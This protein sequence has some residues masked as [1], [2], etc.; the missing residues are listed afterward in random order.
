M[1]EESKQ[2]IDELLSFWFSDAVKKLWFNSTPAFDEELRIK[3]LPLLEK[4]QNGDLNHWQEDPLGALSLVI[5]LDQFPL[6]MFRRQPR[7]FATEQQSRQIAELAVTKGLDQQLDGAQKAFLYMPFMHSE[8]LEDQDKSVD[9][10]E[11]AGL[12]DNLKYAKHH[13]EIVRRYGRFPHRN[14]ILGRQ[15][16]AEEIRYLNSK[17]AFLG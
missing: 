3:Y 17:E 14:S 10:F 8:N 15:S 5:I 2:Q 7:S 11:K 1:D 16:T 4:A 12:T 13:R 6:N 9:L